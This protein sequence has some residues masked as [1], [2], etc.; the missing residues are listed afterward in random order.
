MKEIKPHVHIKQ[1][2]LPWKRMY[3]IRLDIEYIK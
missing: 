3:E 1:V 2:S